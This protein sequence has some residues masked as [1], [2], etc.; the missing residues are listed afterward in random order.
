MMNLNII[1]V[2]QMYLNYKNVDKDGSDYLAN[3]YV[4]KQSLEDAQNSAT[5]E[6]E[7]RNIYVI[8]FLVTFRIILF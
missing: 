5:N 2:M 8:L 6:K 1:K 3:D 4:Y 7:I